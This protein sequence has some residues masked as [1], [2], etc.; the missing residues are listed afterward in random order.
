MKLNHFKTLL[1]TC[2]LLLCVSLTAHAQTQIVNDTFAGTA[3]TLLENHT[4]E[5]GA[6]WTKEFANS[7]VLS[8][9]NRLRSDTAGGV[10]YSASGS[11]ST[12]EYDVTATLKVLST[13]EANQDAGVMV[14]HVA[15]GVGSGNS[16][17]ARFLGGGNNKWQIY[18]IEGNTYTLLN[19]VAGTLA[20][21]STP[22]VTLQV[23]GS[24]TT[25][26][27]LIVDG[28]TVLTATDSTA[29]YTAI[30][31]AAI[32]FGAAQTDSTGIHIDS[33]TVTDPAA[34]P[35]PTPP[36]AKQVIFD[37]NSLTRGY[38]ASTSN[39]YP[40]QT[41]RLLGSQWTGQNFGVDGQTTA[42]MASDAA[43]QIDPLYNTTNYAQNVLVA[44]EVT[45]D[46][47]FGGDATNAYNRFVSYCQARRA[48]G[49]KVV[50]LTVLPRS[51]GSTPTSFETSRQTINA[52]I[53]ANCV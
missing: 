29:P 17:L 25:T 9:A 45:N 31:K 44:W 14:R 28:A 18:K 27:T 8:N 30:G 21:A 51:N 10:V 33:F 23:R 49:F 3:G 52:Q 1:T 37:G 4:G 41:L 2:A 47:Y 16:Y 5:V 32:W 36:T 53:R 42:Q 39:D 35:T 7:A 43:T 11:P 48:A 46:L 22:I 50:V 19:E 20:I 38:G 34:V 6:T 24:S 26:L 40:S 12:N 15:T 13:S